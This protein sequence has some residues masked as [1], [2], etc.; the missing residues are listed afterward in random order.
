MDSLH[1]ISGAGVTAQLAVEE[2]ANAYVASDEAEQERLQKTGQRL[3][4][5]KTGRPRP[6][7][8]AWGARFPKLGAARKEIV[9]PQG[10]GIDEAKAPQAGPEVLG[11]RP[12]PPSLAKKIIAPFAP[13]TTNWLS[14][15]SEEPPI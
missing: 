4:P 11:R 9:H 14:G 3:V 6:S 12:P 8:T 13:N 15:L 10:A 7:P 2:V 5:E 1:Q